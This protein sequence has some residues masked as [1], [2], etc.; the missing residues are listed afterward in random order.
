MEPT[1]QPAV[2]PPRSPYLEG[3]YTPVERELTA[4]DLPVIGA[5]PAD[6]AGMYVRNGSNPRFAPKGRYHWFDGDG[7]VHG[8]HF[9]GG[10]AVY[11]NRYVQ[12]AGLREETAAGHATWSGIM[13]PP[14]FRRR[15]G[16]FKDTANTDLV[17]HAGRLM[18]L[19][20]L[21]GACHQLSLPA[22]ETLGVVDFGSPLKKG[23]S[24]H[25]K[26]DPVTGELMFFDYAL[27]PPYLTYGV[28]S[29]SGQLVHQ[30]PID[31]P[32]ARLQ[33]DIA[34]TAKHTILMDLP[35]MW[36]PAMLARGKT[37]VRFYPELPARFGIIPRHGAPDSIRWFEA[38]AC[39]MY[40]TINAWEE[41]DEVV[42]LGCRIANPLP[43]APDPAKVLPRLDALALEPYLHEWRFNL[44][45]GAVRERQLDDV[46]T[47][48]PRMNN[49]LLGRPSRYSYNPRVAPESTLLYDGV[50]KYDTVAGTSAAYGYGANRYGGEVAFAPRVGAKGEDDG[51]LV[52]F[53]HDRASGR[54]EV[55]VLDARDVGGE[56]VARVVLPQQVPIG[57]HSWWVPAA[58]MAVAG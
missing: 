20:W 10:R 42:L 40:H 21:G 34:I 30:V 50:I 56:P 49:E 32:G 16:P 51:Y 38:S 6:L 33:H 29:A 22:L 55:V 17:F 35:L 7:M 25:P 45:T 14:D 43:D 48:F 18:A 46:M 58:Q 19:W 12:T 53:V 2:T 57:Y 23:L 15:G 37:R 39:Y 28:I 26:V 52:T 9:E 8:V 44:V 24:A 54:G 31:L 11:R 3:P 36:D 4:E 13:E 47:E 41:G 1:A 5:I 27:T